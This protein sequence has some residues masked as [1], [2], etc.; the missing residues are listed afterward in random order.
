[1]RRLRVNTVRPEGCSIIYERRRRVSG[2]MGYRAA[3]PSARPVYQQRAQIGVTALTDPELHC[4]ELHRSLHHRM[5][6]GEWMSEFIDTL[7]VSDEEREGA[8]REL[9]SRHSLDASRV[10][11]DTSR[12][13][14]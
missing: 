13:A 11:A 9:P 6:A 5:T 1:M 12:R 7:S 3:A 4:R 14:G 8:R 10:I 2:E